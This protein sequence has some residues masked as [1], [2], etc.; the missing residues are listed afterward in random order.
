MR[1]WWQ[2]KPLRLIQTNLREID[3]G[4]DPKELVESVRDFGAN[5]LLFNVGG[6]VAN[7]DTRLQFHYR[8]PYCSDPDLVCKV[9]VGCKEHWI[10]FM[11]RF[12][13]SKVNESIA[14][15]HPDWLYRGSVDGVVNYNGQVHTCVNGGYQ[16]ECSLA[17]L[18]EAIDRFALDG[19]FFNM[20]GY[21]ETDYSGVYHG[22]CQCDN[23]RKRFRQMYDQPLPTHPDAN[24]PVYRAYEEF[25]RVTSA[26]LYTKITDFVHR[27]NSEIGICQWS[28]D[29]VDLQRKE[30]NS[31]YHRPQPEYVYEGSENILSVTGSWDDRAALNTAVHF[32]DFPF[33]HAAVQPA[34]TRRRLAQSIATAGSLDYYVIGH[35][36]NQDDR[37][38]LASVRDMFRFHAAN[39]S[40][41]AG[42]TSAADVCLI[43]SDTNRYLGAYQEMRGWYQ[44]LAQAH[45]PVDLLHESLLGI[46]AAA[47]RL[48]RYSVVVL[49]DV[50]ILSKSAAAALDAYVESGGKLAATGQCGTYNHSYERLAG[51]SLASPGI[52]SVT[53]VRPAIDGNYFR[54][55]SSDKTIL[56]DFEDIDIT[57]LSGELLE[58][59]AAPGCTTYLRLIPVH[60]YG[61]PEKC[62]Y[63]EETDIPGMIV[64]TFGQGHCVYVPWSIGQHYERFPTHT[65][66]MI[67]LSIVRNL[68]SYT[69]WIATDLPPT[70]E[71]HS[72]VRRD[73][74]WQLVSLVNLSGQ[75]GRA[76]LDPV[77]V[78]GATLRMQ[79]S[80]QPK[81]VR[82][83][84]ARQ[85]CAVTTLSDGQ[86]E[87]ALPELRL[88]ETL[89]IE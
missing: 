49:P 71:I 22:I 13:F 63:G 67:M 84:V 50:R 55:R 85:A 41:F 18:G 57:H 77:P 75:N 89:V 6:I 61:P 10:R 44:V 83:L 38:C 24:D 80:I 29:G 9:I 72:Q 88:F 27:Q 73:Q 20:I 12:D 37:A 64:H 76:V 78:T 68:L 45:I 56:K 5:V 74:K 36:R 4:L 21:Q 52:L 87:I 35:L 58:C 32:I 26:E 31:G 86:L 81:A 66:A 69:P 54:I 65:H 79:C 53:K 28:I 33:R 11:A 51:V 39:E 59:T 40:Y 7:Y 17:I 46:P 15:D 34:L 16:Q 60:M 82:A 70:V 43:L 23:C 47:N 48:N 25:K 62:Y 30:S 3:A 42:L 14:R 19:V 8:N 2:D 1:K